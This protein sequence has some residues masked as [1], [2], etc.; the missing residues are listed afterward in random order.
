MVINLAAQQPLPVRPRHHL[1]CDKGSGEEADGVGA[2]AAV[3]HRVPLEEDR[4]NVL[5]VAHAKQVPGRRSVLAQLDC[6]QV[7]KHVAINRC[8]TGKRRG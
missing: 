1:S 8:P 4:M 5:L 3:Q 2:V 6:R 7:A